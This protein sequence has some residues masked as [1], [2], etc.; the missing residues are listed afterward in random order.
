MSGKK[1]NEKFRQ[2][3]IKILSYLRFKARNDRGRI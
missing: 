3:P 1:K 2:S